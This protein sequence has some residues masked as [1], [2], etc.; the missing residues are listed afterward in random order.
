MKPHIKFFFSVFLLLG[1]CFSLVGNVNP[2]VSGQA[3]FAGGSG[4][5]GDP[6]LVATAAQ[7]DNVRNHMESHFK[8][9]AHINLGVSPWNTGGGWQPIGT[10]VDQFKGS[11]DGGNFAIRN[12]TINS[13]NAERQGLFGYVNNATLANIRL[14]NVDILARNYVGSLAGFV[15][16]SA[17]ENVFASG[18][19]QGTNMEIGG[20][21]GQLSNSILF[22]AATV[23]DVEGEGRYTGGLV[24]YNYIS[25]I[26]ASSSRGSVQGANQVGG[27]VGYISHSFASVANSYSHASVHG[28]NHVGGLIG[29]ENIIGT[30]RITRSYSTGQVTGIGDPT[31]FGGLIGT[32]SH[33]EKVLN[34]YW[35][36]QTSGQASSAAGEGHTTAEMQQ[37]AT[38]QFFNFA[39]LWTINE[40]KAYP[41][42]QNFDHYQKPQ[43]VDLEA[44]VP[45]AGTEANPYRISTADQLNAIRQNLEAHYR[46]ENDID[47]SSTVIWDYG[48]G[49]QPIGTD[50]EQFKGAFDGAG[51]TLLNLTVNRPH[52]DYQGL[53]G[54][55]WD[56]TL[57]NVRLENVTVIGRK[58]IGSLSGY[59]NVSTIEGLFATGQVQG[60]MGDVGGL[61]GVLN[62][63]TL[64][65]AGTVFDVQG[66]V[67]NV[68]GLVGWN[69]QSTISSTYSMGTVQG[70]ES[71][72]GLVGYHHHNNAYI[73]NSYSRAVVSGDSKV[74]GLVGNL[75][76]AVHD[77]TRVF[78]SYSTGQVNGTGDGMT[79]GGLIGEANTFQWGNN[80]YWDTETS[81]MDV[82]AGGYPRTTTAMTYPY[83]DTFTAFDFI[84]IWAEDTGVQQNDG[85]PYLHIVT[86]PNR[87]I[88]VNAA[89][90]QGGTVSGGGNFH[91]GQTVTVR[92]AAEPG[93]VFENWTLVEDVVSSNSSY[94]FTAGE[95][96]TLTANFVQQMPVSGSIP[97]EGG[98]L[99]S[100]VDQTQYDF[101]PNAFSAPVDV[102]HTFITG[103][104]AEVPAGK[105]SLGYHFE[106]VANF[107][108]G[109]PAQLVGTV[110]LRIDFDAAG[111]SAS[112]PVSLWRL[113]SSGWEQVPSSTQGNLVLMATLD[114]FSTFAL[115]ER[116]P[117]TPVPDGLS[118]FLPLILQ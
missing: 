22:N 85:Y 93:W 72:G 110:D 28:Q 113:S 20:L 33:P 25:E 43:P 73:E 97:V 36:T 108:D 98:M 64:T 118:I 68:G 83:V 67:R 71:V 109:S 74:G 31:T 114:H 92:A 26:H 88:V 86:P 66:H 44:S 80:A 82:S 42:I 84:N 94:T 75:Y 4:T 101:N 46:L 61:V 13:P 79:I 91:D 48:R 60:M 15:N 102:T 17:I 115:F 56:A 9:V 78:N 90:G 23:V 41:V 107:T 7:L 54:Y 3:G 45:G 18:Q 8:Q 116:T 29:A 96:R 62:S 32:A 87:S 34:S 112:E 21:I 51:H 11:Y 57:E 30:G 27:L 104:P 99:F 111:F 55:V 105:T 10:N 39:T 5:Q 95:D 103:A 2:I 77:T 59:V 38:Y 76:K 24:G 58:D 40:G 16:G 52:S 6:Y 47:L 19:V 14:E 117:S 81:G 35:D 1:I 106:V 37:Q 12:L 70:I 49:W 65:N 53:F 100:Q 50:G 63:S 89:P 69:H